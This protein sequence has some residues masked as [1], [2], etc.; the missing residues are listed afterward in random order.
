MPVP[1]SLGCETWVRARGSGGACPASQYGCRDGSAPRPT[2]L[3][4]GA[5]PTSV[6]QRHGAALTVTRS[7]P[8]GKHGNQLRVLVKN[9]CDKRHTGRVSMRAAGDLC[10]SLHDHEAPPPLSRRRVK[11]SGL[12]SNWV[13]V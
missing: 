2:A 12:D 13:F 1:V 5:L 3:P 7:K 8:S 6:Q 10:H 4:T 9:G 11:N